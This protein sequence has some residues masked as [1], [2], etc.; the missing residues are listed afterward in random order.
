MVYFSQNLPNAQ[1][2]ALTP[3]SAS[4]K[5]NNVAFQYVPGKSILQD[6]SFDIE[7]G[8]KYAIVGGSGSG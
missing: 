2:L 8:K 6:L 3:N 4:I 1:L 7:P 5:F